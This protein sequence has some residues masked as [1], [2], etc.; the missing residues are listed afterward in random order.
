MV[1]DFKEK[2][3]R[4]FSWN[5]LLLQAAGILFLL[6]TL[7]LILS[8]YRIYQKKKDLA[9]QVDSY[10]KQI[11]AIKKSSQDLKNKIANSDNIDYLEKL[12][13][14]QLDRQK[15]GEKQVIFITPPKKPVEA[16]QP[17]NFWTSW[18]AGAWNWIKNRF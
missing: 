7:F 6:T 16:P 9:W 8:D 1:A 12:A 5:K 14:E 4:G 13:Y 3:N 15:P 2:R 10:Q 11:E 17:Q 18:L